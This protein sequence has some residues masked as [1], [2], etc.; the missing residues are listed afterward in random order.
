MAAPTEIYVDPSKQT[1]TSCT[2]TNSTTTATVTQTSHGYSNSD[3]IKINGADQAPYNGNFSISNVSANAYDYTMDS[4]PGGNA[5]GTIISSGA[6]LSGLTD[7]SGDISQSRAF[8]S[9]TVVKGT[10]RKST[11]SPRFKSSPLS[12]TIS[13]STGLPITVQLVLDE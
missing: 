4:D 8:S 12:G 13:T 2:I 11:A 9:A 6:I 10:A 3:D 5:T 7:G 1:R